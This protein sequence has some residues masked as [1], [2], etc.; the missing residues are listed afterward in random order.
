[1]LPIFSQW[2]KN[3]GNQMGEGW[4]IGVLRERENVKPLPK[5]LRKLMKWGNVKE[6]LVTWGQCRWI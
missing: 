3:Q 5:R 6:L 4:G 1:M 2:Q